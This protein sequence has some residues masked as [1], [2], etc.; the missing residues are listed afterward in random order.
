MAELLDRR[1]H[2]IVGHSGLVEFAD[3]ATGDRRMPVHPFQVFL[4]AGRRKNRGAIG[5]QPRRDAQPDTRG[6]AGHD[7]SPPAQ[8][9]SHRM[10]ATSATERRSVMSNSA[11]LNAIRKP[12]SLRRSR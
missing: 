2:Q 7:G 1:R 4:A 8:C 9:A 11:L 5:D 3:E 10:I 6:G 12:P